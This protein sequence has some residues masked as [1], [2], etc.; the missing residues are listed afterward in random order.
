VFQRLVHDTASQLNLPVSGVASLLGSVLTLLTNEQSG[1]LEGFLDLFRHVGLQ[2]A[3]KPWSRGKI[4]LGVTG[5][6]LESAL[7]PTRLA[8]LRDTSGL[9]PSAV[10]SA[11]TLLLPDVVSRMRADRPTTRG[12]TG[13]TATDLLASGHP[14]HS[15]N[16]WQK[17]GPWL[18][19]AAF[20][21]AVF[22]WLRA[23]SFDGEAELRLRNDQGRLVY[24][25]TVADTASRNAIVDAL[26]EGFGDAHLQGSLVIDP[27][28]DHPVWLTHVN[29]LVATLKTPGAEMSLSGETVR[30]GGW[31]SAADTRSLNNSV[32][33][34]LGTA[35]TIRL[36]DVTTETIRAAN[37]KAVAAL[38]AVGASD[39]S[40]DQVVEAMSEAIIDFP[41]GSAEI[42]ADA[43]TVIRKSAEAIARAPSDTRIEIGG[44][45]D[46]AGDPASNMTLSQAR[47][48]AVKA[49]LVMA[50]AP[51]ARLLARGYGDT[52][53]RGSNDTEYGRFQ[54]RRIEYRIV[55]GA[56]P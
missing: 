25:G 27:H 48:E 32:H 40:A 14:L 51:D 15:R 21:G 46:S 38:V 39:V 4:A 41:S 7:G 1:G 55:T 17:W 3:I 11:L 18:A 6:Q 26:Q 22:G 31:L 10:L 29:D 19:A 53:P 37:D 36:L 33:Q 52:R 20:V 35:A 24:T 30:V 34:I 54:N 42:P 2:R 12:T 23:P 45:T 9:S 49:A 56:R 16:R 5:P 47:A 43:T 44:H 50:G 13:E 28:V 8:H